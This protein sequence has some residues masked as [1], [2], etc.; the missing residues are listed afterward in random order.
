M[1]LPEDRS[2]ASYVFADDMAEVRA[3]LPD[4]DIVFHYGRPREALRDA[5]ALSRRLRW[6]H[7]GAVGVDWATFPE[8]IES[9]VVLTNSRGVFDMTMPEYLLALMLALA[10]DIPR[11]VR[12]QG[13][14][15]WEH[16]LLQALAGSCAVIVGAGSIGRA[17]ARLLR[18]L[19]VEV[20]LVGRREREDDDDGRIR[21]VDDLHDLLSSADWLLL[22]APLTAETRGLIGARELAALPPRARIVN[23]GRGPVLAE[24]ALVAALSSGALAGA[25]LDVFEDEPLPAS[26]PLWSMANVIVSPHIGGDVADTPAAFARSFLA[27]LERYIAGEPLADIVDKRLGYVR[28]K[29]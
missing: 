8:L 16:R 11:T 24:S 20:I 3:S 17:S 14:R 21:A 2:G 13:E 15:R 26:S 7:V 5:W 9:E 4:C 28:S 23:I 10:K 6:V 12:A 25:A 1:G 27:N 29:R 19:G 22:I 18:S